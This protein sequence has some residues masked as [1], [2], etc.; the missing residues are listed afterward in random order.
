MY[1]Y[2]EGKEIALYRRAVGQLAQLD[3]LRR[4]LEAAL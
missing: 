1:G 3:S 2:A 4:A